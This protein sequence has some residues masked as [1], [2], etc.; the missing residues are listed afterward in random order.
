[1][2]ACEKKRGVA[3]EKAPGASIVWN[4]NN[5]NT[6]TM[7]LTAMPEVSEVVTEAA[8]IAAERNMPLQRPLV[9]DSESIWM[10]T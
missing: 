9:L 3:L 5:P 10:R 8:E 4:G 7:P 2:L 1:M 6:K